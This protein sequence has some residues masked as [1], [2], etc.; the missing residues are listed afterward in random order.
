MIITIVTEHSLAPVLCTWCLISYLILTILM[1]FVFLAAPGWAEAYRLYMIQIQMVG[2][3][4]LSQ[5]LLLFCLTSLGL[6]FGCFVL[7]LCLFFICRSWKLG[8]WSLKSLSSKISSC[9]F[10]YL[11][12]FPCL[13]LL[14][15]TH[16]LS[17]VNFTGFIITGWTGYFPHWAMRLHVSACGLVLWL[18]GGRCWS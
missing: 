18:C 13:S 17:S 6:S 11:H 15:L 9:F 2:L 5:S 8:Y 16:P 14:P 3:P 4:S 12:P 10:H 7:F 1:C